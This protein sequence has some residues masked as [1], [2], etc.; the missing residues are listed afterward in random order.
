MAIVICSSPGENEQLCYNVIECI[1]GGHHPL[2]TTLFLIHILTVWL[3]YGVS[4]LI[5]HKLKPE[6]KNLPAWLNKLLL[7][8]IK[9]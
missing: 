3:I 6:K 7:D 5:F 2:T 8:C 4:T 9:H 1:L